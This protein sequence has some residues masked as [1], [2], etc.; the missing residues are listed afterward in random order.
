[1]PEFVKT[2]AENGSWQ[3]EYKN[4]NIGTQPDSLFEVPSDYSKF[5]LPS[6]QDMMQNAIKGALGN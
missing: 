6:V 5:S 2:I 3:V 1:M 4:I